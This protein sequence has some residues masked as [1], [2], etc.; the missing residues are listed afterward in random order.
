MKRRGPIRPVSDKRLAEADERI[1]VV[2][3]THERAKF[4]CEGR[5]HLPGPCSPHGRG[6]GGNAY[7]LDC[8]ELRPRGRGGSHLNLDNTVSLCRAHHDYVTLNRGPEMHPWVQSGHG[9]FVGRRALAEL[10][11]WPPA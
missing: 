10:E 11:G 3:A 6:P 8:N 7:G 4:R 2:A 1:A 5:D 9:P